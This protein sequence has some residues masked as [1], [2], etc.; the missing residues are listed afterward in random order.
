MGGSGGESGPTK[1]IDREGDSRNS[2]SC[3][4]SFEPLLTVHLYIFVYKYLYTYICF[5]TNGNIISECQNLLRSGPHRTMDKPF[6]FERDRETGK[7]FGA[8]HID[9]FVTDLFPSF[10]YKL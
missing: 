8:H 3:T 4:F 5:A 1:E 6:V 2:L 9:V 7:E 10:S